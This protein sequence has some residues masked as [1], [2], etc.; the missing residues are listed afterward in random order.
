MPIT[1]SQKAVFAGSFDPFTLAHAEIV[2]QARLIFPEVIVAVAGDTGKAR[3]A[4]ADVRRKIAE[5]SLSL[6]G[7]RV[8]SFSGLLTD[9]MAAEKAVFMIRGLRD[10]M[11][12][13]YEQNISE[14]YKSQNADFEQ[15]YFLSDHKF[16][17][18]SGTI[19][20]ELA[21]LGGNLNGYV[22]EGARTLVYKIYGQ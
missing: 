4:S 10:F 9:F 3:V 8:T 17:H 5:A 7:V 19:V 6:P 1:R 20:R 14:V 21:R 13:I 12:L 11:D 2:R 22:A 15:V 16:M 18:I